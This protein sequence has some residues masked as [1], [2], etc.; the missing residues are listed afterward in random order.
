MDVHATLAHLIGAKLPAVKQDGLNLAPLLLGQ[1]GATGREEFWY[2]STDELHAVRQ[3]D[4]KLHVP[5]DYLA[6][7]A[8]P[9]RGGKPSNFGQIRPGASGA[10]ANSG[11]LGIA[12]RHGY[13]FTPIGVALYNLKDDP[14][15]TRDLAAT[16]PDIVLRLQKVAAAARA[17]LGDALT[18]VKP[19][20]ARPVGMAP[21]ELP[22]KS[23][24]P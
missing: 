11:L 10:I 19:T 20:N 17:D 9:G 23:P 2:Y 6:L 22:A 3:G 8:A 15:E 24:T 12:S 5:H 13:K 1:P 18:G 4:W 14:G 7:V 16:H 21:S